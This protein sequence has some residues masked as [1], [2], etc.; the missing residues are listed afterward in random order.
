[1]CINQ[2]DFPFAGLSLSGISLVIYTLISKNKNTWSDYIFAFCAIILA[3]NFFFKTSW[4]VL[5]FS[6]FVFVFANSF[7]IYKDNKTKTAGIVQ[8]F[9]P[10]LFAFVEVIGIKDTLGII[11]LNTTFGKYNLKTPNS[12]LIANI[13]ITIVILTIIIPLLSYSNVY[14][15]QFVQSIWDSI[16]LFVKDIFTIWFIF[17]AF[18]FAFFCFWL[19]K[20]FCY[21]NS[22]NLDKNFEVETNKQIVE[23]KNLISNLA[24]TIS[25]EPVDFN[26]K[27]YSLTLPKSVVAV[28]LFGFFV[29]QIQ[30]YFYPNLLRTTSGN[31]ANEVFFHLSVVCLIVF[32]LIFINLRHNIIA[33]ILSAILVL[34]CGFLTFVAFSSDWSYINNWGLTHKRLYGFMVIA[35][36]V[37]IILA[38]TKDLIQ[39]KNLSKLTRNIALVICIFLGIGNAINF[40]YLIYRNPPRESAGIEQDYIRA[41]NLDSYSL[42]SEFESQKDV[43]N[44]DP[45][46]EYINPECSDLKWAVYNN[47]Q[48]QYLQSKYSNLQILGFNYNEYQNYLGVKNIKTIDKNSLNEL[49]GELYYDNFKFI[50]KQ[51]T[52]PKDC[53]IR[54]ENKL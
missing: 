29:A 9:V 49:S 20:L 50:Q 44:F 1:M 18:L 47:N 3:A 12:K 23:D 33:R 34:E 37:G 10:F 5:L 17:K 16:Y 52:T 25:L 35:T 28:T 21:C 46:K 2:Y 45:K 40:D 24:P 27:D 26:T 39:S 38:F 41:M 32:I 51:K 31:I 53:Y 42:V 11:S 48:I 30:T 43:L 6:F 8:L 19:P 54:S 14:F 13:L 22:A 15:G 4:L 36:I 7:L